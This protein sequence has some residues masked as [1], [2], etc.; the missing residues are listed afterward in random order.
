MLA[1]TVLNFVSVVVGVAAVVDVDEV[2]DVSALVVKVI[3]QIIVIKSVKRLPKFQSIF[4]NFNKRACHTNAGTSTNI[5][6]AAIFRQ[7]I[8][9]QKPHITENAN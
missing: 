3:L 5:V 4:I 1:D 7:R 9:R 8:F 2:V 6:L